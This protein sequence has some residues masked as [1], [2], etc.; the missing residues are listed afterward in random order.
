[1]SGL[2]HLE[3]VLDM[4]NHG[5]IS[6]RQDHLAQLIPTVLASPFRYDYLDGPQEEHTLSRSTPTVLIQASERSLSI[7]WVAITMGVLS[8]LSPRMRHTDWTHING[9]EVV[10]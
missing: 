6:Q 7:Q 9:L 1:M 5:K 10:G 2:D 4:V 3:V 8:S